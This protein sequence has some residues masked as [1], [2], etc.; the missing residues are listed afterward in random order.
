VRFE[1]TE[2]SIGHTTLFLSTNNSVPALTHLLKA[3]GTTTLVVHPSL[4]SNGRAAIDDLAQA[5]PDQACRL[6]DIADKA[7][8]DTVD[9]VK[10]YPRALTPEE[11]G[12]LPV[13]IVHSSGSTGFPKVSRL[14]LPKLQCAYS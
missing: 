4:A 7:L 11:E 6:V 10:A 2:S 12:P 5:A 14:V 3:T 9:P 13:F 1:L 8:W